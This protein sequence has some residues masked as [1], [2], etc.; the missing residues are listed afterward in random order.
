MAKPNQPRVTGRELVVEVLAAS[1]KP[2]RAS[3]IAE[4]VLASGRASGLKGKTP[5]ATIGALLAVGAKPGGLF[6]RT[7]PGT[8]RLSPAGKKAAAEALELE[9]EQVEVAPG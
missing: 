1:R 3:E 5:A 6:V 7:A 4:A 8:F 9:L 2:M